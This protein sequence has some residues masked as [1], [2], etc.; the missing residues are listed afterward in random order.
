MR[1]PEVIEEY[2]RKISEEEEKI[3]QEKREVTSVLYH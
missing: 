2:R 1:E 3:Q